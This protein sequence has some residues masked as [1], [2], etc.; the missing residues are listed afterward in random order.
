MRTSS[1]PIIYVTKP[2][3]IDEIKDVKMRSGFKPRAEALEDYQSYLYCI[4]EDGENKIL[5]GKNELWPF[6]QSLQEIY[7]SKKK[8]TDLKKIS[9]HR[10]WKKENQKKK[11]I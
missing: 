6:K 7:R 5:I 9:S 4:M 1:E 8:Y 11:K 10:W 2:S 3:S